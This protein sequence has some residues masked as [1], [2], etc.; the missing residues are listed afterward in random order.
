M[1]VVKEK[2]IDFVL[3]L[4]ISKWEGKQRISRMDIAVKDLCR[5]SCRGSVVNIPDEAP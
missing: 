4:V 2:E 5:S 3:K 1:H